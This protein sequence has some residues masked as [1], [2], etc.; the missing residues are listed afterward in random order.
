MDANEHVV[1]ELFRL[2]AESRTDEAVELLAPDVEWRNTG[3]PTF[4]GP[5]VGAMLRDAEKRGVAVEIEVH[6][7]A[8]DGDVVLTDRTDTLRLG[9]WSTSFW[10]R[11]T[12]RVTDG[13]IALWD[14]AFSWTDL[15]RGG[16]LGLRGLF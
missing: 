16:V 1:R 8:A 13:R 3:L 7:A 15:V 4:R 2:L 14:D 9:G 10:V 12:F 5:R 11:G 6:H